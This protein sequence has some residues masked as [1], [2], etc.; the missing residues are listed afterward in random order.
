MAPDTLW[1]PAGSLQPG[2]LSEMPKGSLAL[3]SAHGHGKAP[4]LGVRF[5]DQDDRYLYQLLGGEPPRD[6]PGRAVLITPHGDL[7]YRV[8]LPFE[9][10]ADLTAPVLGWGVEDP[11]AGTLAAGA[12]GPTLLARIG[13]QVGFSQVAPISLS[14]WIVVSE[15]GL[16]TVFGRWRVR[17]EVGRDQIVALTVGGG[18]T[19]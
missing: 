15:S 19:A 16:N 11:R 5:D 6:Q 9:V 10:E 7:G 12:S 3:R 14:D 17:I 4:I 8:D 18:T 2:P 13:P 1:L